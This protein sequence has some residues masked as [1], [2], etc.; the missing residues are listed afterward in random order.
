MSE[1]R[2]QVAKQCEAVA[3]MATALAKVNTDYASM[4]RGGCM[5]N[6]T[7]IV[8]RRTAHLMEVLGNIL[9]N[10]DA[11]DAKEYEWM[12]PV[13][14]EAQRLWPTSESSS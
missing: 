5:D 9:N 7:E 3:H 12:N 6:L 14:K 10:M 4:F 13:F 8:G 2:E 1:K 11:V